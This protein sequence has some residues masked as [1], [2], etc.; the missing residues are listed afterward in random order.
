[1]DIRVLYSDNGTLSDFTK[2]VNNY[3]SGTS[4]ISSFLY[5]EDYIYIGQR[6]PFNSLFFKFGTANTTSSTVTV[7]IWDG[8][9]WSSAV[10]VFDETL[11]SGASFGQD[12]YLSWN[13]DRNE[14]WGLED[15]VSNS[16]TTLITGLGGVE[17][18]DHYWIQLSFSASLDANTSMT[19]V[20]QKFC[21][22]AEM[23]TF[24]A[25]LVLS[26]TMTGWESGKT[27]WEEQ[28]VAC[29]R[30]IA[31]RLRRDGIIDHSGQILDRDDFSEACI[32]RTAE[33]AYSQ[34]GPRY[35]EARA[36]AMKKYEDC[37]KNVQPIIDRNA[38]GDIDRNELKFQQGS[39]TR[40][41]L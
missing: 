32:H 40:G 35:E 4:T 14:L 31:K 25:D 27:T 11:S 26:A 33:I 23:G 12:G 3:H 29:S 22:Q 7:K 37:M 1:M 38:D 20:G 30:L 18:Y 34:M 2:N 10:E 28:H 6:M 21:T 36:L 24:Y 16:G 5:T 17:I 41:A 13:V 9:S 19:F 39:L 8:N 15:T